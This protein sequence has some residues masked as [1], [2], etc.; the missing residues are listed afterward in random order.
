MFFR[1]QEQINMVANIH[2][3]LY[4]V[5]HEKLLEKYYS[6]GQGAQSSP[7]ISNHT[8]QLKQLRVVIST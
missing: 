3:E 2:E 8:E 6:K 4:E 5:F 1:W 7:K